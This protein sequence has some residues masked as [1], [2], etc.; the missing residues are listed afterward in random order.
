MCG[1]T[2]TFC[3]KVIRNKRRIQANRKARAAE[4]RDDKRLYLGNLAARAELLLLRAPK[5]EDVGKSL[6]TCAQ[7]N[8]CTNMIGC[9]PV[10][11][12]S[13][14]SK[15]G[16]L[17]S[18]SILAILLGE[19]LAVSQDLPF[20]QRVRI[21]PIPAKLEWLNTGGPLSFEGLRGKF[22]LLDFWTYCCI[23][24]MHLLPELEKLEKAYPRELV[25][26]G[27]HSPKFDAERDSA[28]I[29]EAIRRYGIRHPVINDKDRILWNLFGVRAWPTLVLL[30]PEGFAIWSKSGETPFEVLDRV[31]RPAVEFYRKK[32]FLDTTPLGFGLEVRRPKDL[33]L[34]YPGKVAVDEK[35]RW[36]FVADS[37][38]N[39]IVVTT[40]EGQLLEIIGTGRRALV[41]GTYSE[42]CFNDP[43]GLAVHGSVL[44]VAD[45]KN[46]TIRKVDLVQKRVTTIAGTGRQLTFPGPLRPVSPRKQAL[47][48][49]W[50]VCVHG[51]YLYIAM[52]GTHQ[53][54]RLSL[55]EKVIEVF[56]GNGRE[57][58]VDGR[59]RPTRPF[60]W[61][62]ASF[63]Q[64]SG[65][66]TDG[67]WLYV[68]DSEGSSIRAVPFD[69]TGRVRTVVGTAH[70]PVARLFTF[71]D[72]DGDATTARFQHPLAVAYHEGVLYV[73]DTY[74][75]KIRKVDPQSGY[76]ET[77]V[78]TG[79][80]GQSDVPPR[81][82]EPGGLAVAEGKLFVAD[83]NNHLIRVVDLKSKEV[84]TLQIAGLTPPSSTTPLAEEEELSA[85][86]EFRLRSQ[87]VRSGA[88]GSLMLRVLVPI[89]RGWKLNP[90]APM[91]Y[92][93]EE[94]DEKE[95]ATGLLDPEGVGKE[96]L[97]QPPQAE[98]EIPLRLTKETGES[99]LRFTL[100]YFVCTEGQ[101]GLCRIE[102]A[103]WEF[104]LELRPEGSADPIVLTA[105]AS[106]P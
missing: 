105:E 84:K 24:C 11:F 52:A 83:T 22:V 15:Y 4:D 62:Y 50:D 38:H 61:G 35:N 5:P 70:L 97:V 100:T 95:G 88:A 94:L 2:P 53:I 21:P 68:A 37:G 18:I 82:F 81:F 46:H 59:L 13:C 106:S 47:A 60:E 103:R 23:N 9:R 85:K 101:E 19:R 79:E 34:H 26:V 102:S 20:S 30:D 86:R 78:G 8:S 69:L 41:D 66:A 67:R 56:A 12:S 1:T 76:T 29:V 17:V 25:V 32:G 63:A 96:I 39:R 10:I 40:W 93:I 87:I 7:E 71:G 48:S 91:S 74:N 54:W 73:A 104:P 55:D 65:L 77:F 16:G 89:P 45:T 36:L 72:V 33:P 57:D 90:L 92:R 75:N 64:P 31:L 43:Q 28:R 6:G 49:P 3:G 42:A 99:I 44:Y 27:V 98:L 51:D 14:F 80:R 58:I